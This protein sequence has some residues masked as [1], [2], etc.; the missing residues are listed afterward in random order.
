MRI[1]HKITT[2]LCVFFL[3]LALV[4]ALAPMVFSEESRMKYFL[5]IAKPNDAAWATMIES[6]GDLAIPAAASLE[7]MGGE[8][9]SYYIGIGEAK[10]YGVVAFPDSINIAEI[11][12]MRIAQG[13]MEEIH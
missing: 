1:A 8:L 6:G 9:I 10:N 3:P 11:V 12:Y 13:I 7:S 4:F 2:A 5:M